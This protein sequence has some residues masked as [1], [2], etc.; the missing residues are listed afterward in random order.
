MVSFEPIIA[1]ITVRRYLSNMKTRTFRQISGHMWVDHFLHTS[2]FKLF[3]EG[4]LIQ[5]QTP[6]PFLHPP[7]PSGQIYSCNISAYEGKYW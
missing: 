1:H 2:F 3:F 5:N 7:L 6:P 4:V